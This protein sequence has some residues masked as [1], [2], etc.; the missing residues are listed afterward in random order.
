MG[1]RDFTTKSELGKPG[2]Q[3]GDAKRGEGVPGEKDKPSKKKKKVRAVTG[4]DQKQPWEKTGLRD[5]AKV[6]AS[7][8]SNGSPRNLGER[9]KSRTSYSHKGPGPIT[10]SVKKEG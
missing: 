3:D 7:R 4:R 5:K 8:A 2:S 10:E 1:L 6:R 9:R